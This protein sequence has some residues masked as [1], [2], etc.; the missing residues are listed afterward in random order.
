MTWE[1]LIACVGLAGAVC[2]IVF[3]VINNRRAVNTNTK[4]D[5]T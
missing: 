1:L 5:V 2:A 3:G 4:D